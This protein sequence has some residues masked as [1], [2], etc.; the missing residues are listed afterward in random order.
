MDHIEQLKKI[1]SDA[2][3]RLRRSPDFKLAG[4]L[5]TLIKELGETVEEVSE[6]NLDEEPEPGKK[7]TPFL[8]S[9]TEKKEPEN[10]SSGIKAV[11]P[12]TAEVK[13]AITKTADNKAPENKAPVAKIEEAKP[14]KPAN[15]I[16]VDLSELSTD[17][18]VDELVAEMANDDEI[19]ALVEKAVGKTGASASAKASFKVANKAA[20][21]PQQANSGAA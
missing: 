10:K 18:M 21:V 17:K 12:Q 2:I 15:D 14:A 13:A 1:R 8:S 5:G 6:L 4:K 11:E 19:E 16:E 3:E 7:V 20:D 9:I